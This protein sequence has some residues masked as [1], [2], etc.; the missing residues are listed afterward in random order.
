MSRPLSILRTWTS[1]QIAALGF[2]VWW[3]GNGIAVF[4]ASPASLATLSTSGQVRFLDTAIAVNGWHG[5]FHLLTGAVGIATCW[6][7][8]ASNAYALSMGCIYTAAALLSLVTGGI[9]FGLIRV[10]ELGSI[11]HALEGA[12]LLLIWLDSAVSGRSRPRATSLG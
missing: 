12:L 5:L 9:V 11:D 4:V 6:S 8:R 2:G 1:A 7:P 10:D 3:I